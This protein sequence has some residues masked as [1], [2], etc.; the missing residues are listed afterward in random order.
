MNKNDLSELDLAPWAKIEN[1]VC[2]SQIKVSA[3]LDDFGNTWRS[4]LI[5]FTQMI[6]I[7]LWIMSDEIRIPTDLN[8]GRMY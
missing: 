1:K 8:P 3:L 5:E 2:F 4:K 6:P 7:H